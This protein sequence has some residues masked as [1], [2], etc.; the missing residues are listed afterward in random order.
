MANSIIRVGVQFVQTPGVSFTYRADE[1]HR[2]GKAAALSGALKL[3]RSN[4]GVPVDVFDADTLAKV[5][6]FEIAKDE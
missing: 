5:A 3:A 4:P 2:Y 6:S 1:A